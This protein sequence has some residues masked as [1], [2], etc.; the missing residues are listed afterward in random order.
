LLRMSNFGVTVDHPLFLPPRDFRCRVT[1]ARQSRVRPSQSIRHF[2]FDPRFRGI[3]LIAALA[4][5]H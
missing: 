1:Y 5:P 3:R 2:Q 4:L